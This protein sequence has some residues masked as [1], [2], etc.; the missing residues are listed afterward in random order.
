[1]EIPEVRCKQCGWQGDA[2]DAEP[3]LS[4]YHDLRCPQCGTSNLDTSG[5]NK[6]WAEAG[7]EYGYGDDNF[8]QAVPKGGNDA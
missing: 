3:C 6:S 8:L 7:E 1:M 2:A 4:S 5:L